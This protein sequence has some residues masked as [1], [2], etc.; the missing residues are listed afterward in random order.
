MTK[1]KR[2]LNDIRKRGG[3]NREDTAKE[4]LDDGYISKSDTVLFIVG[5]F[6][7]IAIYSYLQFCVVPNQDSYENAKPWIKAL[8]AFIAALSAVFDWSIRN[9][10]DTIEIKLSGEAA[11]CIKHT[12]VYRQRLS[13]K[14]ILR[15][16]FIILALILALFGLG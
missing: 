15:A 3:K 6:I 4:I 14:E 5:C 11:D 9:M 13:H 7:L 12:N 1:A 8:A 2:G 16:L 10:K